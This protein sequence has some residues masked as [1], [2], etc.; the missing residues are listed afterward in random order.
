M[1]WMEDV[2]S[3]FWIPGFVP[4]ERRRKLQVCPF[5]S[6]GTSFMNL[7]RKDANILG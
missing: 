3:P 1:K 7:D 5:L 6:C 2:Y 4:M